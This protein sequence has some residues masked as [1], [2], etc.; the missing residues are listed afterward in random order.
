MN[1]RPIDTVRHGLLLL[2]FFWMSTG[3]RLGNGPLVA[4]AA[5]VIFDPS[6]WKAAWVKRGM[7]PSTRWLWPS[8]ALFALTASFGLFS[9]P[10]NTANLMQVRS[11]F[12]V[13][14]LVLLLLGPERLPGRRVLLAATWLGLFATA[15][16]GLGL[17]WWRAEHQAEPGQAYAAY[18]FYDHYSFPLGWHPAYMSLFAGLLIMA[19]GLERFLTPGT[20]AWPK[21][22]TGGALLSMVVLFFILQG[23]M[24]W[25]A[26]GVTLPLTLVLFIRT[27]M[28]GGIPWIRLGAFG[29]GLLLSLGWLLWKG[30]ESIRSRWTQ[31]FSLEYDLDADRIEAFSGFTIRLAEWEGVR[32]ALQRAPWYGF[33]ADAQRELER[34]YADIGFVLGVQNRYN[35]H[36][37]YYQILLQGG[38]AGLA[39]LLWFLIGLGRRGW[40]NRDP[41]LF[42]AVVFF[43]LS[44]LTESL[45]DR[46]KGVLFAAVL[47]LAL[48]ASSARPL[49]Q[50]KRT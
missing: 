21:W 9:D 13:F 27:L 44:G 16:Y 32:H 14:P 30:P 11:A 23:R 39:L 8:M 3:E 7:R 1:P 6:L 22:A 31:G 46:Q 12:V 19:S 15:L 20:P 5:L 47:L 28:P 26:L 35:A 18:F 37:M 36:N 29:G 17:S 48:S 45:I 42:A 43:A 4:L 24:N 38:W 50:A 33:G 49:P 34:S 41:L 25:I 2:S 10:K 40:K